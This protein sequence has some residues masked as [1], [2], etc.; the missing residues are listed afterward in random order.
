MLVVV[1][2]VIVID[3]ER[4]GWWVFDHQGVTFMQSSAAAGD[5]AKS[6]SKFFAKLQESARADIDAKVATPAKKPKGKGKDNAK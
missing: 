5:V 3:I 6:S 4:C 2:I 1:V